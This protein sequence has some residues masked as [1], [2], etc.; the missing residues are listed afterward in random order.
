VRTLD[1]LVELIERKTQGVVFD[2]TADEILALLLA[3]PHRT[4]SS[5]AVELGVS[6]RHLYRKCIY[7]FGYGPSVLARIIRFQRFA[8]LVDT[9]RLRFR[10]HALPPS[11]LAWLAVAAGYADQAH[12]VRDCREIAG[13]TPSAFLNESFA[14]FPDMSDPYKTPVPLVSMLGR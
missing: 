9:D 1:A 8:A 14:T 4:S 12:L 5:V 7:L 11:T 3:N 10:R 6:P 13:V 2:P